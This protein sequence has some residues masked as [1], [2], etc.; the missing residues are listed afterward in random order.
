MTLSLRLATEADAPFLLAWRND[1]ET[2]A[3]SRRTHE[4]TWPELIEAPVKGV[5]RETY[6]AEIDGVPVGSVRLD[7][8]EELCEVSWTVA[9]TRRRRGIGLGMVRLAVAQCTA[10]VLLAEIKPTNTAS[11]RIAERAGFIEI[12][13]R[14]G[15]EIWRL[16]SR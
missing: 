8:E 14:E 16:V 10:R 5:R 11:R 9:P 15:F 7:Y 4:L 13:E 1:P 12:G 3:N 2:R 6:V